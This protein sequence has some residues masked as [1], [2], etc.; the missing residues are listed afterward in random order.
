M[1]AMMATAAAAVASRSW[2]VGVHGLSK[3]R[4]RG[5]H[6]GPFGLND[7]IFAGFRPELGICG[8]RYGPGCV[9]P[10]PMMA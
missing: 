8:A 5:T 4:A 10:A 1:S 2:V 9:T 7:L 6:H 3:G